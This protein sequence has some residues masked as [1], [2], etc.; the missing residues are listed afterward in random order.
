MA[1]I[2]KKET[3]RIFIDVQDYLNNSS[4]HGLSKIALSTNWY[5][6]C[7][8]GFA[9]LSFLI[10]CILS[11]RGILEEF[12]AFEAYVV[13]KTHTERAHKF[14]S[15]TIC[16][17]NNIQAN[18]IKSFYNHDEFIQDLV[19]RSKRHD[20][21]LPFESYSTYWSY[22][23]ENA[24]Y[25]LKTRAAS[26]ALFPGK[27]DGWC[28]FR[29]AFNCTESD[30]AD[31]FHHAIIGVC[32]TFNHNGKYQ[33]ISPGPL[34]GLTMKLF[35]NQSNYAGMAPFD[36]GAGVSIIVHPQDVFPDSIDNGILL[37]AGTLTRVVI[38]RRVIK[39]LPHPYPSK[40]EN[41]RGTDLLPGR[42][43]VQNCFKSFLHAIS[44][45]KCGLLDSV[46]PINLKKDG[47]DIPAKFQPPAIKLDKADQ[48]ACMLKH[49]REAMSGNVKWDCPLPCE[50][51]KFSLSISSSTWPSRADME[52]YRPTLGILLNKTD[53]TEEYIYDNMLSVQIFFE[54]MDYEEIVEVP[55]RTDASLLGSLGGAIGLFI[56]ASLYS[57]LEL[58]AFV[59]K[60]IIKYCCRKAPVHA[61]DVT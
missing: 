28:T 41:R 27:I 60:T 15:I 20:I 26:K 4:I 56:G 1:E 48:A 39:R 34:S 23:I 8:W 9:F 61:S 54:S 5:S 22:G 2:E 51:E 44:Y 43:S 32:K 16:N 25:I 33:Q 6:R 12:L 13:Y 29:S 35:I 47:R 3:K 57:V 14:P 31:A 40:C 59:A 45:T 17:T 37:Q 52:Y 53:I 55:A 10:A 49:Y 36:N 7:I 38:N 18:K 46:V 50:E 30:F 24:T 21:L 58:L 42:Y 11:C 19:N